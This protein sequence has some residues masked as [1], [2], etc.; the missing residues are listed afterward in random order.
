MSEA[1]L[2]KILADSLGEGVLDL[3]ERRTECQEVFL[4]FG[5]T[6]AGHLIV[7]LAAAAAVGSRELPGAKP[8]AFLGFSVSGNV[9]AAIIL[10]LQTL[11]RTYSPDQQSLVRDWHKTLDRKLSIVALVLFTV[12]DA[13]AFLTVITVP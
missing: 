8:Y 5:Q 6:Q 7:H 1:V 3:R 11:L 9:L 4:N 12:I 13:A 2:I 10:G